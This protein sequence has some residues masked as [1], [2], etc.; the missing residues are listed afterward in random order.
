MQ[1]HGRPLH[2]AFVNP[3][4]GA[5]AFPVS[6]D[7][8]DDSDPPAAATFNVA[9][10]GLADRTTYLQNRLGSYR[11]TAI[12]QFGSA[13]Q[14]VTTTPWSANTLTTINTYQGLSNASALLGGSP[15][16]AKATDIIEV[17]FSTSCATTAPGNV[18]VVGLGFS[19]SSVS[20]GALEI[21]SDTVRNVALASPGNLGSPLVLT[22]T[23]SVGADGDTFNFGVMG[24]TDTTAAVISLFSAWQ[25]TVKVWSLN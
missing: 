14:S 25:I 15:P 20:A 23:V 12:Y 17:I 3:Y 9:T 19:D 24:R 5:D 16:T 4:D 2:A 13:A 10:E 7:V 8:P 18:L 1:R 11:L 21:M 6:I 22:T